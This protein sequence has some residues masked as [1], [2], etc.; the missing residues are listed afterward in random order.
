MEFI[1]L[2]QRTLLLLA[3]GSAA[4][5]LAGFSCYAQTSTDVLSTNA[6]R[7]ALSSKR[8]LV[9]ATPNDPQ[10]RIDLAY[11]LMDSGLAEDA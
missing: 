1:P 11:T 7:A 4:S 2:M 10:L 3:L 6:V 5:S 9:A 8:A